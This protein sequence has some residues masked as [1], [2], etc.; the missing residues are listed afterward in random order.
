MEGRLTWES[1]RCLAVLRNAFLS[2]KPECWPCLVVPK[3]CL[4][5]HATVIPAY[6]HTGDWEC[7]PPFIPSPPL[8]SSFWTFCSLGDLNSSYRDAT[9]SRRSLSAPKFHSLWLGITLGKA[10]IF[11]LKVWNTFVLY[12]K[13]TT[14]VCLISAWCPRRER[15]TC[16]LRVGQEEEEV[17]LPCG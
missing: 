16:P 17:H 15:E 9:W 3:C 10:W 12:W 7:N 1:T 13:G 14:C 11:P 6:G 8:S 2:V 4:Y 5:L